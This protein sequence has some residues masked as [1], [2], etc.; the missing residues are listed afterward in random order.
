MWKSLN[1]SSTYDYLSN[2]FLPIYISDYLSTSLPICLSSFYLSTSLSICLHLC[3][4]LY[5]EA[6]GK[7]PIKQLSIPLFTYLNLQ[8]ILS[9]TKK[10]YIYLSIIC[11]H[12]DGSNFTSFLKFFQHFEFVAW[13]D[14]LIDISLSLV[15]QR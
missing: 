7:S 9:F 14:W 6:W 8:Y 11:G 2:L 12:C 1:I 13:Y 5:S 3:L 4:K 10:Y 15:F